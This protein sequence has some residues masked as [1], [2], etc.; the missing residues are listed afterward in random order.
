MLQSNLYNERSSYNTKLF[1]VN[2]FYKINMNGNKMGKITHVPKNKA[3][4]KNS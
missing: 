1:Y 3:L 2:I 4:K